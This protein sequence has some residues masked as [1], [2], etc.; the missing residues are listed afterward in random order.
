MKYIFL[1]NLTLV[2]K[3]YIQ[4]FVCVIIHICT[5]Y[6]RIQNA[7]LQLTPNKNEYKTKPVNI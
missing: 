6:M 7:Q 3:L 2:F 4:K 5:Y 1:V